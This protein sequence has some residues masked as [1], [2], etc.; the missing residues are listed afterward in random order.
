MKIFIKS[1]LSEDLLYDKLY[2]VSNKLLE[3]GYSEPKEEI[4]QDIKVIQ[5]II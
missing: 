3:L 1:N 2:E 5:L 4:L